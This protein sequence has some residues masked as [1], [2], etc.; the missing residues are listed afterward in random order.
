MTGGRSAFQKAIQCILAGR[1][2]GGTGFQ[3]VHDRNG[4]FDM[5]L[6]LADGMQSRALAWT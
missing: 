4:R 3:R 1:G 5:M 2:K 6:D